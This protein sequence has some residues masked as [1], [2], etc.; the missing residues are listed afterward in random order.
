MKK[1][2]I[3]FLFISIFLSCDSIRVSS[4][5]NKD[6]DFSNLKTYAFSKQGVDKVKINDIDKKRILKAIDVELYNKGFRKVGFKCTRRY[7]AANDG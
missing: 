7:K 6:I 2:T 5:Y 1:I 3:L 4:D